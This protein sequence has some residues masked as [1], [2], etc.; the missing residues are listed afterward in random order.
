MRRRW[1]IEAS[2]SLAGIRPEAGRFDSVD[3]AYLVVIGGIAADA[4]RPD[5]R[6]LRRPDQHAAR[7]RNHSSVRHGVERGEEHGRLDGTPGAVP[8]AEPHAENN[9]CLADANVGP[10]QTG[11]D[12]KSAERREGK[13]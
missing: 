13:K 5:D 11:A 3:R 1:R 10:E 12:Q 6:A 9:P 4:D 8:S 7:I 2:V